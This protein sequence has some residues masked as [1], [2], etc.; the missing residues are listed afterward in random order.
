MTTQQ[1][2]DIEQVTAEQLINDAPTPAAA[3]VIRAASRT[4]PTGDALVADI[5][6]RHDGRWLNELTLDE[7]RDT[8]RYYHGLTEW[9]HTPAPVDSQ[10]DQVP[11]RGTGVTPAWFT[12]D[13]HGW[14]CRHPHPDP[15]TPCAVNRMYSPLAVR[16]ALDHLDEHHPGWKVTCRRCRRPQWNAEGSRYCFDCR[17]ACGY[18]L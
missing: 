17:R 4:A 3:E 15:R 8:W 11:E 18:T 12:F 13:E 9:P 16:S 14:S 2:D 6:A 5:V 7:L 10:A 1:L